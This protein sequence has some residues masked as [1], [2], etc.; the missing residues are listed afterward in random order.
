MS[1]VSLLIL[2][3]F[4]LNLSFSQINIQWEARFEHP[5]NFIDQAVDLELD[6]SG[7]TYVTGTS[8]NGANYDWVTVKYDPNGNE[9]WQTSYGGAGLDEAEAMVMDSNGDIIVT[10]SRFISGNDYDIAVVKYNGTTGA[11]IWAQIFTGSS[12]FDAGRDVTVDGLNN[13]ILTGTF[14]FSA[15]D[16]DWIIIKYNSAGVFQWSDS[17]GTANNDEGKVIVADAANNYYVAG[18][19]QFSVGTTYFDF[20]VMKYNSAGTQLASS[21]QDAGFLG[22]DTPHCMGLDAAGN[23]FVGG[24][25]FNAPIEE[26]DYVLMKFNNGLVHQWTRTYSGD[27]TTLDRINALDI[28]PISGNVYVTGRSKSNASSEDYYTIAYNTSGTELWNHRYTS[29]GLGFDEATAIDIVPSGFIYITG[30]TFNSGS[31]NDYTTLKYDNS[32][33]LVWDT[34]FN[35]PAG[36]SDQAIQMRVDASENIFVTGK[37]HGGSTNFDY[38]TIKYCQLTTVA[39]PDAELCLGQTVDLTATGGLTPTWAVLS[40]DAGSLSCTSCGTTTVNPN[41]TTVYTV[42]TTS[43]SGCID[44]DTVTVVVNAIPTPTIYNDT[45]LSFCIGGFVELYTDTYASYVWNTAATDS[46]IVAN[47]GGLY[48]VT[49]TDTNGCQ[50]SANATVAT[51]SLPNV[52]AGASFSVCPGN[53]GN[54]AATGASTYLWN[55][56]PSLSQLNIP[57]PV[58]TPTVNSWYYVTGTDVNGCKKVD[59]VEVTLFTLPVVNAGLDAQ[60]CVGDSTQFNATGAVSFVWNASSSLSSLVIPNPYAFPTSLTTYTVT[61]TDANG[62]T[63]Q[64][65]VS[66]STLSL[67][68]VNAGANDSHCLGGTS[69]L[70]ATGALTWVWD[71]DPNISSVNIQNPTV[72]NT[73]DKWFKVTG[74]DVNGCSKKDSVFISVDPLPV[75]SV[76][77]DFSICIGDSTQLLATGANTYVWNSHPTFLSPTNVANPWVKPIVMTTY[78]VTGTVTATGCQNTDQVIVSLSPLPTISAGPDAAMCIGDSIQ[79]NA[80]GGDTYIWNN[81]ASLS[82]NII[83][84]PWS[85]TTSTITYHVDAYD[86]NGCFGEDDITITVNPLPG[87]P[88]ILEIGP[89]LISSYT[90]G[91]QWYFNGSPVAG[92]TNDSL[93]WVDEGLNGSYTLLYTNAN[94]CEKFSEVTNIIVIDDIGFNEN[95]AFEVNL[96]P[97]PTNGTLN[98]DVQEDLDF[99]FITSANGQILMQQKDLKAGTQILDLSELPD[100]MYMIQLVIDDRIVNRRIIKQ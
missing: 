83:A 81:G 37:S 64:D 54:L 75:V 62:C 97:N 49:I 52:D 12:N 72:N 59:S 51:F 71:A 17:N 18:H 60:V 76:G 40:G 92:G 88:V 32:G 45:P 77:A 25:G 78:T 10:G 96:Y 58:A 100:G 16:I 39:S 8:F 20:L 82:S 79:L 14:S 68:G 6:A 21:S 48:T 55:T 93:N 86:S 34:K 4:F 22:L 94:G 43:A 53:S 85:Y 36:L 13:V 35:G 41:T 42:F 2:C 95:Y 73:V 67:P 50:N 66:V 90:T 24:Q 47:T 26:E 63:D 89:W 27:N 80:T 11:Q 44:Y 9:L 38:S 3:T 15:S 56:N 70:F 87:A 5:A 23:L 28:D 84:D 69:Q 99:L 74:T 29:A 57:N 1:R 91:N 65:Q 46:F 33:N 30:Y 7:N 19:T 98:I 31:N 61:G